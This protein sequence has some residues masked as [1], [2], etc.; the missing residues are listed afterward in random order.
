MKSRLLFLGALALAAC[1][2]DPVAPDPDAGVDAGRLAPYDA[3]VVAAPDASLRED[4]SNTRPDAGFT[5]P[6]TI[7]AGKEMIPVRSVIDPNRPSSLLTYLEIHGTTTSTLP[8]VFVLARGPGTSSEY[9]P[10]S[11]R[12]LVRGR[13][14]VYYDIR[15]SGRTSYGDG[16]SN[17]TITVAQHVEDFSALVDYV[18]ALPGLDTSK[19]DLVAHG[20]GALLATRY[21]SAHASRV[22][23]LVVINPF[24]LDIDRY[25]GR[26]A[27]TE[28]RIGTVDRDRLYHLTQRPECWGNDEECFILAWRIVGPYLTCP[29]KRDT[30]AELTFTK[31][32][33]RNEFGYIPQDLRGRQYDDRPALAAITAATTV[34]TG[35]C[36]VT[37]AEVGLAYASGVRDV[38]HVHLE[39]VGEF[40][41]VESPAVFAATVRRALHRPN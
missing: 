8:P 33:F 22:E 4:A 26:Q 38:T 18:G 19:I 7:R 23:R 14:V 16:T 36:E 3:G 40:G 12:F 5:D 25:V 15:G 34:I 31:G 32:S 20:Y 2:D 41:M 29:A 10:D 1:G 27:E 35:G 9:L 13:T 21:A 28:R 39:D 24:P 11:M 30:F 6:D 17:S 37:P